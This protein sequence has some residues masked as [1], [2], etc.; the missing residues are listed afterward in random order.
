MVLNSSPKTLQSFFDGMRSVFSKPQ[1]LHMRCFVGA[2]LVLGRAGLRAL[3]DSAA[4]GKHRT[5]LG[6]FLNSPG[7]DERALL[8]EQCRRTLRS[9]KPGKGDTL[10]LLIDDTRIVKR[11]R[12]MDDV[13][14]LWDHAGRRFARGHTVVT[15]AVHF[16]GV[17]L[18]WR[19]DLW[20]SKASAGREYLKP[21][22]IAAAM[23]RDFTPPK[24]VKVR[25]LFDAYYLCD[26]VTKAC[27][28]RGFSWFSVA[29]KN[30]K[31]TRQRGKS[32]SLK[33]I[34][35]GVLKY[36]GHKVRL[37]RRPGWRWMRIAKTDGRLA[38]I[39]D[40]RIVFSKRPRD[41]WKKL[42]AVATNERARKAR[43]IIAIYE[44]R[45][46]IEL[47][48]KELKGELG[49]CDYRVQK[50]KGIRRHLHLVCLA[51]LTLTRHSLKTVD[52]KAKTAHAEISLP[53][54]RERL[55]HL[56]DTVRK[57]QI[58]AFTKRIKHDKIRK[59]VKAYLLAA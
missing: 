21:T 44:K 47:L 39:G 3:A 50:R 35:P 20:R 34:G 25:V 36:A 29:S 15:A 27:V 46:H 5:S 14:K 23:I 33:S 4:F 22:E 31:L 57:D 54:F 8:A 10:Y 48:F 40:V 24:S 2:V 45:W 1:F 26:K 55:T 56:R 16:R 9:L 11:A 58:T 42:L 53:T 12:T 49:L 37:K 51:H 41:P 13:S 19:L 28:V 59:R 32:G 7:W 30:R 52:A 17:T 38:K 6:R 43:E 18:P